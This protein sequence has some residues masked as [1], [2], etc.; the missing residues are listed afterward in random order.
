M[1]APRQWSREIASSE[2]IDLQATAMAASFDGRFV[3][4]G[5]RKYTAL[6]SRRNSAF[7]VVAKVSRV[8]KWDVSKIAWGASTI[9]VAVNDKVDLMETTG[10]ALHHLRATLSAHTRA[11]TDLTWTSDASVLATTSL[12]GFIYFWDGREKAPSPTMTFNASRATSQVRFDPRNDLKFAT[13]HEGEIRTW[14]ARRPNAPTAYIT[15]HGAKIL[16][17]DW[18]DDDK[19]ATSAQDCTLKIFDASRKPLETLTTGVAVWKARFTPFGF[20]LATVALP[21]MKRKE[22]SLFLWR[23]KRLDYPVHCF[24]GHTDVILDFEWIKSGIGDYEMVS[25]HC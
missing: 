9:A 24:Y 25:I 4:L 3:V 21:Q 2:H 1:T 12:D 13:S 19:M 11:V 8:R 5:G 23:T 16:S 18:R 15:A 20:G 6:L 17:L 14:D 22:N 7:E 10:D